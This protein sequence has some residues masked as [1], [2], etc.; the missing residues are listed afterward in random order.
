MFGETFNDISIAP[1]SAQADYNLAVKAWKAG[2][3]GEAIRRL[4]RVLH[5]VQD[6]TV[7]HHASLDI[8]IPDVARAAVEFVKVGS[9]NIL[10]NSSQ[11]RYEGDTAYAYMTGTFNQGLLQTSIAQLQN[12]NDIGRSIPDVLIGIRSQVQQSQMM[13]KTDGYSNGGLAKRASI[14]SWAKNLW[15][16]IVQAVKSFTNEVVTELTKLKDALVQGVRSTAGNQLQQVVEEHLNSTYKYRGVN[17]DFGLAAMTLVPIAIVES[18][19]ILD[20]FMFDIGWSVCGTS[21]AGCSR[22]ATKL[23]RMSLTC[24]GGLVSNEQVVDLSSGYRNYKCTSRYKEQCID[25]GTFDGYYMEWCEYAGPTCGSTGNKRYACDPG[26]VPP[27]TCKATVLHRTVYR[28]DGTLQSP[29]T[30]VDLTNGYRN[31]KCANR[32]KESCVDDGTWDG[33]YSE[34]CEYLCN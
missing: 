7:P 2:D 34:W 21:Q 30:T 3:K 31:Y 20:R 6:I 1:Y 26:A 10:A 23:H 33:Y 12:N 27:G 5:Y 13:G 28:C 4:G 16:Q 32:F 8:N 22:P 29:E 25:D 14:L 11:S 9:A 17:D 15:N 19:K 24:T 18:A